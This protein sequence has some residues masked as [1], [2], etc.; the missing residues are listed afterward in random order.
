MPF[1]QVFD[2]GSRG[3]FYDIQFFRD[4]ETAEVVAR[5]EPNDSFSNESRPVIVESALRAV[6]GDKKAMAHMFAVLLA[7]TE[8]DA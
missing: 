1:V 3:P 5:L 2:D 4:P 7:E 6:W 8:A